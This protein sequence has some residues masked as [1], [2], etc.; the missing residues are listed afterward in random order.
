[1]KKILVSTLFLVAVTFNLGCSTRMAR[2]AMVGAAVVGTAVMLAEPTAHFHH[3]N[4]GCPRYHEDGRWV[5]HYEGGSEYYDAHSGV[6][7][8]Y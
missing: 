1:M 7:Y 2:T 6:W 5:Y 8:R 3:I 4:C